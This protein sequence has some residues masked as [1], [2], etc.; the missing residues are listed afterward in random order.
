MKA[1]KYLAASCL[2]AASATSQAALINFTGEIEYHNDVVY[3][4]FTLNQDTNNVRV[5]TDSFQNGD[6]FDPITALW[7][8]DGNLIAQND[9]DDSV[10]PDTQTYYDSGFNLSFLEAGDYIFTVATYNNFASGNSLSDGFNFDG[11]NP[12]PLA[13]WDQ[14]ANDVNMGPNWSVW[15]DGADSASNPGA[16]D[17]VAVPEPGTLALIATGLLGLGLR[18]RK[19][20]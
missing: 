2:L 16:D 14:P 12:I 7:S 5:W 15:L 1:M 10:N 11:Q 19:Q 9:D 8:G 20:A 18:R 4:Y 17:P 6:N 3:T 13:D